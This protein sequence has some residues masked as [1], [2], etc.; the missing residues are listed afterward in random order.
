MAF[1]FMKACEI[2]RYCTLLIAVACTAFGAATAEV[3]ATISEVDQGQGWLRVEVRNNTGKTLTAYVLGLR[4]AGPHGEL[5]QQTIDHWQ[6]LVTSR[7]RPH[8]WAF[9]PGGPS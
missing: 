6:T 1:L 2:V 5:M 9:G 3:S 8:N 7:A 4:Y